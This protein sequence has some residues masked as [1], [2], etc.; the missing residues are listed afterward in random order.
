MTMMDLL[1]QIAAYGA[2]AFFMPQVMPGITVS[3]GRAALA[4][5]ATFTV[6]NLM[7]GWLVTL[8]VALLSLPAILLTLGLFKL[9]IPAVVNAVLLHLTDQFLD[10]FELKSWKQALVMG[11]AFGLVARFL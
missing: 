1:I 5:G 11:F 7:L 10:D 2:V 8:V 9:L 3:G 4:V 6:V